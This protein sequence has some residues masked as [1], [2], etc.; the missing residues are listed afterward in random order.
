[1]RVA[2]NGS[3]FL[4]DSGAPFNRVDQT[5]RPA[6]ACQ[7]GE[8]ANKKCSNGDEAVYEGEAEFAERISLSFEEYKATYT[9]SSGF[10][11]HS[12]DRCHDLDVSNIT[13]IKL[14]MVIEDQTR[15]Y[16]IQYSGQSTMAAVSL[17]SG[18]AV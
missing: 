11:A 14:Y 10:D 15:R 6:R 5:L 9:S 3:G 2:P 8:A 1:M 17:V 13:V 18:P 12:L 4:E 7:R 16:P